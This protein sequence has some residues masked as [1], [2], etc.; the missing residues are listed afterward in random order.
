ME[1]ANGDEHGVAVVQCDNPSQEYVD[2]IHGKVVKAL[3][4]NYN[5]HR[6]LLPGWEKKPL[7]LA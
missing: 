1:C 7:H 3:V 2:E 4:D 6:H 5:L